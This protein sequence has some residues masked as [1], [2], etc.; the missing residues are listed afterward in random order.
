MT[1]CVRTKLY[2]CSFRVCT[3]RAPFLLQWQQTE[4]SH[5][6]LD[7]RAGKDYLLLFLLY[8]CSI[9]LSNLKL[10]TVKISILFKRSH[11]FISTYHL[12]LLTN[13]TTQSVSWFTREEQAPNSIP[14]TWLQFVIYFTS[15]HAVDFI[16]LAFQ[17]VDALFFSHISVS[18]VPHN[19]WDGHESNVVNHFLSLAHTHTDSQTP[20][21]SL[22]LF[23]SLTCICH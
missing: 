1:S 7:S 19:R 8:F 6:R 4:T 14:W 12:T 22:F 23:V 20:P 21:L 11:A 13:T 2:P 10:Q 17:C 5:V 9:V 15:E 16:E 18:P 3:H